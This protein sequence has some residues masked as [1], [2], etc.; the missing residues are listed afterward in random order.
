MILAD[1]NIDHNLIEALRSVGIE[2]MSIYEEFRGISDYSIIEISRNPSRIIL[3]EDKDFGEWVF[4]HQVKD[5]SVVLLR[6][7]LKETEA[8]K[9]LS[10][11][12]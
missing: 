12:F 6:Y 10:F 2:V 1:E 8:I 7:E 5:I 3:T 11:R 9:K 4:A